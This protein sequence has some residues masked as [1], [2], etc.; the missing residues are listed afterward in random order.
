[1]KNT[2][3]AVG[4]KTECQQMIYQYSTIYKKGS[5]QLNKSYY[6]AEENEDINLIDIEN[7]TNSDNPNFFNTEKLVALVGNGKTSE[8]ETRT[9]IDTAQLMFAIRNSNV[10]DVTLPTVSFAYENPVEISASSISEANYTIN[11]LEYNGENKDNTN[12]LVNNIE[13]A[14]NSTNNRGSSKYMSIQKEAVNG[15]KNNALIIEY[16]E[17]LLSGLSTIG[18][19]VYKLNKVTINV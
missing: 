2:Y 6:S 3:L 15:I 1:M 16:A 12:M 8:Y 18:A 17:P 4:E 7:T 10:G 9:I 19:L 13:F 14:I 11:K 5:Y